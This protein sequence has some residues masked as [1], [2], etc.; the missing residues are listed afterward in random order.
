[1]PSNAMSMGRNAPRFDI[2][3]DYLLIFLHC[4]IIPLNLF[5]IRHATKEMFPAI[6]L[7][8]FLWIMMGFSSLASMLRIIDFTT[9]GFPALIYLKDLIFYLA[10]YIALLMHLE[11][12]FSEI[13]Y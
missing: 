4:V 10:V 6:S 13:S 7:R 2:P 12:F 11:V 5:C 9:Y 1:M 8:V 3:T